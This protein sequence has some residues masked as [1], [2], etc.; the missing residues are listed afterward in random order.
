MEVLITGGNG[1]LGSHLIKRLL[2]DESF[3]LVLTHRDGS[4]FRRLEGYLRR[5]RLKL[6]NL[7]RVTIEELFQKHEI[8]AIIHTATEYGRHNPSPSKILETNLILPIKLIEVGLKHGLEVFLNTDSYFNKEN[9]SYTNLL[10]YSLSKKSL[11]IWLRYFSKRVKVVNLVLEHIFG[12]NDSPDKFAENMIQKIA[13]QKVPS[14]DL[15]F[16]HQRRDFIYVEDA[17]EAYF[18]ALKYAFENKFRFKT[19][20][21]GTG[22]SLQIARFV[23][24]LKTVSG[25]PTELQFGKIPYRSDEIMDSCADISELENLGW[26]PKYTVEAALAKVLSVYLNPTH[27]RQ[28]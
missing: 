4:S 7:D 19:F 15:T 14:V 16:G 2:K 10:D 27:K 3:S 23:E 13:L 9:F 11:N 18:V 21:V 5:D 24:I 6:C 12:E 22:R 28:S 25:S 8:K 1:F 26:S 20:E 17:V